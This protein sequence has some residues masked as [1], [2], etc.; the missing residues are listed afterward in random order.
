[1]V[2]ETKVHGLHD[3]AIYLQR[4][5]VHDNTQFKAI[6]IVGIRGIGK[7]T[8]C[9]LIF[10][11]E[12]VKAHFLPKIWV[13]MSKQPGDNQDYRKETVKRILA[14]LDVEEEMIKS[15]NK[16]HG[17]EGLLYTLQLQLI[18]KRYL[19]VLDDVW[20]TEDEY[21]NFCSS[22]ADDEKCSERL[23]YGLPK[24]WGGER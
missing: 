21:K 23:A 8:L 9:Q 13:W 2:D 11:K 14:C 16:R 12:I 7:T 24:G 10:N 19:I 17:L 3:K 18:G 15:D 20:S 6:G 4:L 5:L 1:M 22:I